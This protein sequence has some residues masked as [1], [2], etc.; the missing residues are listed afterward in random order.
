MSN[1]FKKI[2]FKAQ[3]QKIEVPSR[4]SANGSSQVEHSRDLISNLFDNAQFKKLTFFLLIT[5]LFTSCLKNES[6]DKQIKSLDSLS[7]ALNQK[8]IELRQVDTVILKKAITKYNNY[9]QFIQQNVSDTVTKIEADHIQQFF[10]CG[11]NLNDFYENRNSILARGDLINSQ[12]NKLI[13]DAK[14]NALDE[15]KLIQYS[16]QEKNNAEQLIKNSFGQQQLFQANLQEFKLSL[17]GIEGLIRA[18]NN[19]QMPTVIKDSI[20]L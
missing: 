11:K 14:E 19:G 2:T 18:R 15:E 7:G 20:P 5:F 6:Y 13:H 1:F 8:L 12:L 17:S 16:T 10:V 4:A 9:K 3:S